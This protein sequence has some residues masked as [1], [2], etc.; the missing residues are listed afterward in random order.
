MNVTKM[1]AYIPS[2]VKSSIIDFHNVTMK[3]GKP[4][5]RV[6]LDRLLTDEEKATMK[7]SKHFQGVD[8]LC[9]HLYAPEIVR[10]YFYVV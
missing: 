10:S 6:T 5:M 3:S 7:K 4:G 1:I 2:T 8:L 9:H